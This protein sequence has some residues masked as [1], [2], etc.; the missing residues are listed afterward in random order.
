MQI[1]TNTIS[2]AS[3]GRTLGILRTTLG[4][5]PL[6]RADWPGRSRGKS[7]KTTTRL[8]PYPPLTRKTHIKTGSKQREAS[9]PS[10]S[11][12]FFST[13]TFFFLITRT[14][15]LLAASFNRDIAG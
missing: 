2:L 4:A 7:R 13:K 9:D 5:L 6:P 15:F 14:L 12:L 1:V 3:A 8:A 11:L 10:S